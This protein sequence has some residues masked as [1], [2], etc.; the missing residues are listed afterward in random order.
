VALWSQGSIPFDTR[1]DR[2]ALLTCQMPQSMRSLLLQTKVCVSSGCQKRNA[3]SCGASRTSAS[4]HAR[5][6]RHIVDILSTRQPVT[7]ASG[8][9][10]KRSCTF[11]LMASDVES[12]SG[13]WCAWRDANTSYSPQMQQNCYQRKRPLD[14]LAL[15]KEAELWLA[16]LCLPESFFTA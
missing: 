13:L 9:R 14:A 16:P 7:A 3:S 6:T 12:Q 2:W 10:M 1:W 11:V 4:T 5:R 15:W 8:A